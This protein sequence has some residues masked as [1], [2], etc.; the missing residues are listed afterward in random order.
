MSN[1][2]PNKSDF[3]YVTVKKQT[4]DVEDSFGNVTKLEVVDNSYQ[5]QVF[6]VVATDD[7]HILGKM[8]YGGYSFDKKPILFRKERYTFYPVGPFILKELGLSNEAD[9]IV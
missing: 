7:T 5:N 1:Y 8:V 6:Q 4:R 3:I 9:K 2:L